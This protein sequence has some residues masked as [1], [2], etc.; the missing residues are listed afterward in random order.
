MQHLQELDLIGP[1]RQAAAK[2][3]PFLGICLGTQIL[4][5]VQKRMAR[6]RHWGYS[7][8]ES[9][10]SRRLTDGTRFRKSDGTKYTSNSLIRY[11]RI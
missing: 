8:D 6:L 4:F 11:L 9:R 5:D 10:D 7:P 1:L 2:G 3:I